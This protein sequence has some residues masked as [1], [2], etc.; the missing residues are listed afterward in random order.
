MSISDDSIDIQNNNE[1]AE[2]ISTSH[3][4]V[5]PE[6]HPNSVEK[7][8]EV[9]SNDI[10]QPILP[11]NT[12]TKYKSLE[13][14]LVQ[15]KP[16]NNKLVQEN[17]IDGLEMQPQQFETDRI[18]QVEEGNVQEEYIKHKEYKLQEERIKAETQKLYEREKLLNSRISQEAEIHKKYRIQK[19][20]Y[21][22]LNKIHINCVN[23]NAYHN[24]RYH[25]YKNVLFT[26]FR[27]PLIIL[28]GVNSFFSVG[29][30]KYIKQDHV[31]II[32]AI[33]SL[34]CGIL[35]SIEL[36]LNL[37]KRME[38][39]LDCGK[40]YYKL[41][42]DIYAELL[43]EPDDRGENGDLGKFLNDKHN[44]YQTLHQKSNAVNISER[45]FDDEFELYI[46]HA[47]NSKTYYPDTNSTT[48]TDKKEEDD[49]K[50]EHS[51]KQIG[52]SNS[53]SRNNHNT[54]DCCSYMA[55]CL[56]YFMCHC[57][58][59]KSHISSNRTY[60]IESSNRYQ[61]PIRYY[62]YDEYSDSEDE[63]G[64]FSRTMLNKNHRKFT[65]QC[66]IRKKKK[67]IDFLGL[68]L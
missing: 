48:D 28:N 2:N 18:H 10:I 40:E 68:N 39:E 5:I 56:L 35:T 45:D 7:Y 55:E 34:V 67:L 61:T 19:R 41:S 38:L 46:K 64:N 12:T 60:D 24:N 14:M 54:Q 44:I 17:V 36:L 11:P 52:R 50:Y 31:S 15:K 59:S 66:S 32:N 16:A 8:I 49:K 53:I 27:V 51:T 9:F 25:L 65:Q 47:S 22:I 26:I 1:T 42:V 3:D 6:P 20:R 4:D 29:L 21:Q 23:L 62:G 13:N 37:Q 30:Q 33:I 58:S 63:F 57:C 43:K